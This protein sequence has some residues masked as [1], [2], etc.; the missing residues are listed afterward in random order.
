MFN[1]FNGKVPLIDYPWHT[2]VDRLARWSIL[3]ENHVKAFCFDLIMSL[4]YIDATSGIERYIETCRSV[5]N[6][7]NAHLG[8]I[9]LCSPCYEQK[10]QWI[11]QKAA[12][13][14]S[15]ALGK[16]S[17]EV[18]LRFIKTLFP[19]FNSVLSVGGTES[20]DA[21]IKHDNGT[22]ILAEVKSAPLITYPVIFNLPIIQNDHE[23]VTL[24]SSQLRECES[25]LYLHENI[26]ISLGKVK[27]ELWPFK[28]A[29]DFITSE[30]NNALTEKII[31]TWLQAKNAYKSKDRNNKFY[32]L[33]NASGSPPVIAKSRDKWPKTES[34]SDSK[35]SAGMDRTD[36]IKKGIYQALK[37]GVNYNKA[38]IKTAL[39][40]NLPAYRH[41]ENYVSPFIDMLWSYEQDV[42]NLSGLMVIERQNL[43]RV[44]D[45]IITLD[46]SILRDLKNDFTKP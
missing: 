28:Q 29:I 3:Q 18:V 44:F 46:E 7:Y 22:I 8:F 21:I 42:K 33:A 45:Y 41:G 2:E 40:S 14:Q 17:S 34:I 12:K 37:I 20:A 15:G 31:S 11:Y 10:N 39:I 38:E 26:S 4:A 19:Q 25:A 5:P 36:D 9:N 27:G 1:E 35:T 30:D 43:K 24:T 6:G 23:T 13:P 16:L 32:Y